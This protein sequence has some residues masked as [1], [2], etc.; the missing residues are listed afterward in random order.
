[1]YE[2]NLEKCF[3]A[4]GEREKGE[5]VIAHQI[6]GKESNGDLPSRVEKRICAGLHRAGNKSRETPAPLATS[7]DACTIKMEGNQSHS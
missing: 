3:H 4:E 1:M 7:L 6:E 2:K 5:N